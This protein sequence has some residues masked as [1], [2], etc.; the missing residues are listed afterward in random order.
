ME[1]VGLET[2]VT[3]LGGPFSSQGRHRILCPW[4]KWVCLHP[5]I[6]LL[7]DSFWELTSFKKYPPK[8]QTLGLGF[9]GQTSG[10]G[11]GLNLQFHSGR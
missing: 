9:V 11:M 3:A 6:P 8:T 5:S 10:I 4:R 1:E 7:P 2:L